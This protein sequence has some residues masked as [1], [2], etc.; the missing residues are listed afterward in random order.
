M[1]KLRKRYHMDHQYATPHSLVL[2]HTR[3]KIDVWRKRAEN[4]VLSL[5]TDP[6]W[7]DKDWLYFDDDP[8]AAPPDNCSYVEDINTGEAFLAT[9]RQLITKPNQILVAIPLYIDGAVTGQYDKLQV[10]ALKMSIGIL[11]RH[12]RD[13]EYAWKSLGYVTN[14][15]KEDS[16]G[17]KMFVES[18]HV[19][20]HGMYAN[21]MSDDEEGGNAAAETDVDKAADYHG[22]LSVL[23]ESLFQLVEEGM[24]VDIFYKGRLHKNCELVFF[25]PFVKCDGDEGDKLCC[26]YRSRG[27]H[28]QQLCR[29]CQCP[30]A[31]T[32]NP[33]ANYPYKTEPMLRKL[34]EQNNVQ[35]LKQL[36]QIP[37][38]NA[39]HGLRFGLQN[40]RGIHGACP[41]ELLHAI[42]LGIFKYARDCFFAQ[43]GPT[44]ATAEEINALAKQIGV[45]LHRQS[46]RNKPRTKF[47]KGIL[48]GKLM[49]KEYTGVLL[50]MA[51]ILR[52]QAGQDILKS[53]RKKNFQLEWQI[54]DWI[55][56]VET[57]LQ[58]E[59]YLNLPRMEKIHVRR[60]KKKHRYLMFL[61]KKV[62]NRTEGM[63]FKVMKFH[64][65][66]H[67]AFDILMFSVPMNVDTGSNESHHKVT[68]IAAKLTQKD[69]KNFEKQT[70]NR[71]DDFHVLDLA[72]EELN[73][74]PLWKYF[75]GYHHM[76]TP[77]VQLEAETMQKTGG[78]KLKVF[79]DIEQNDI[80]ARIVTKGT[81]V[82]VDFEK[83]FLEFAF[84][85]QEDLE[86]VLP[87]GIT[88]CA[89]H[90]RNGQ[91]FRTNPHYRDAMWK[92][93]VM[94]AWEGSDNPAQIWGFIDLTE[95]EVG[96]EVLLRNGLTV[97]RGVFA[98]IE[99]CDYI[100]EEEEGT[101]QSEL[102]RPL[103]LETQLIT[104]GKVALRKFYLVDVETF[105]KPIVVIP[106]IG[107]E[108]NCKYLLM[109]PRVQWAEDFIAWIEMPHADD[110]TEMV[111]S[112][113][114]QEEEQSDG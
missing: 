50:I 28:V 84:R 81:A 58:W 86:G 47:S 85:I 29:Y 77:E 88:I 16:R 67:L 21:S 98:V 59:A 46:D 63:G 74:R 83:Q 65:I 51:A 76:E 113:D 102:F 22:I 111:A 13:K 44:S 40:D 60:L 48:K 56:L 62:G 6:R 54:K 68:K 78:M 97:N 8:F 92:D 7:K 73:G 80:H 2:P 66:I 100:D 10:T 32:D 87:S 25:I 42:L 52:C 30:N 43:M 69:I 45:L 55:L 1:D 19:A 71:M 49:A 15:T 89:E 31:E 108:P 14:Y 101:P 82:D 23:L 53:A 35:R 5:L 39:F 75:E 70:S 72:M 24:V 94:I 37:I 41:W 34:F 3:S 114:E 26:S 64:A 93:W 90:T 33:N 17:K 96:T 11:N 57:L 110:E 27:A 112:E 91:M 61:L 12:A 20:V 38:A 99:S 109:A 107:S 105:K 18:G 104:D 9:Y 4:N 95:L 103:M 36:S 79:W 106:D